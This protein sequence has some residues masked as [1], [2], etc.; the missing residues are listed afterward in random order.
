MCKHEE[1]KCPR[2]NTAF[3]CKVGDIMKCQCY[4]IEISVAEEA[5]IKTT[6][7]DCLCSNCLLQLKQRYHLFVEQKVFYA[8][9]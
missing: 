4:G 9:R 8:N 6:Y 7:S 5:F 3:E 1:K 2:C